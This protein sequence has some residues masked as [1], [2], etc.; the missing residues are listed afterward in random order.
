[1]RA[2]VGAGMFPPMLHEVLWL[3]ESS[4][5]M[6]AVS[7]D[8]LNQLGLTPVLVNKQM[9]LV[10]QTHLLIYLFKDMYFTVMPWRQ[11]HNWVI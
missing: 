10:Q 9:K 11:H 1:M 5:E 8:I 3:S 7:G 6:L 4:Q 2:G